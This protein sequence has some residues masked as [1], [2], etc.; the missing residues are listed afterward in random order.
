M[1]EVRNGGQDGI[2]LTL[3][4]IKMRNLRSYK[5]IERYTMKESSRYTWQPEGYYQQLT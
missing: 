5:Q 1:N 3:P 2:I 4:R